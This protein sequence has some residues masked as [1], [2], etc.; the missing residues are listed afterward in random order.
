MCYYYLI[1]EKSD[2]IYID[3][4]G[5]SLLGEAEVKV[6]SDS[7]KKHDLEVEIIFGNTELSIMA[8]DTDSGNQCKAKFDL[9]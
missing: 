2:P 4:E 9:I 5:C 7:S 1:P 6:L 8:K 3:E